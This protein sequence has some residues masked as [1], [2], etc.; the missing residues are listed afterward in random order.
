MHAKWPFSLFQILCKFLETLVEP[1]GSTE[2]QNFFS[3]YVDW[4]LT[5][6]QKETTFS[7]RMY[8]YIRKVL[9]EMSNS[10]TGRACHAHLVKERIMDHLFEIE[11]LFSFCSL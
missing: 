5:D 7:W 1:S 10:D 6:R 2:N 11:L 4:S 3:L 9:K 8:Q